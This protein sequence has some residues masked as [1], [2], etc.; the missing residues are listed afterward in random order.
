MR[1]IARA[2]LQ[3]LGFTP[4]DDA[5]SGAAALSKL[6]AGGYGFVISA[7]NMPA[8]DGVELLAA[9]R[10]DDALKHLPVLLATAE[11]KPEIVRATQAGAS[12]Y[13]IKPYN[14]AT[15]GERIADVLKKR[16]S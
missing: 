15:L 4:V 5:E 13:V 12:G 2:M 11:E 3:E 8:M 7:W 14:A 10:A 6:Q 16:A 9:I 1:R